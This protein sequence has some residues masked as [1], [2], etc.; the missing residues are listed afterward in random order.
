MRI[1]ILLNDPLE[2]LVSI[3]AAWSLDSTAA[4]LRPY[5]AERVPRL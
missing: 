5:G 2:I 4:V 1:L 3:L